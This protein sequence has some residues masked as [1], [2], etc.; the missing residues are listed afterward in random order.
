MI[1]DSYE[2][3]GGIIPK[4]QILK[5][6]ESY[7]KAKDKAPYIK[8]FNKIGLES[9]D[10]EKP[11]QSNEWTTKYKPELLN[12]LSQIQAPTEWK[13]MVM[14][15][16]RIEYYAWGLVNIQKVHPNKVFDKYG[17]NWSRLMKDIGN[18]NFQN[19]GKELSNPNY[20]YWK[21]FCKLK[22]SIEDYYFGDVLS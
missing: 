15:A 11:K 5:Y 12:V 4:E 9:K 2:W 10:Y 13:K 8:F 6:I 19:Y 17:D 7:W 16:M 20:P 14:D 21:V 18:P 3:N 1:K 22:G